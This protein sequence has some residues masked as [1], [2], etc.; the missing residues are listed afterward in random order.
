MLTTELRP[1]PR[2]RRKKSGM[3]MLPMILLLDRIYRFMLR[4]QMV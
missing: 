2:K 4:S 1:N 3:A